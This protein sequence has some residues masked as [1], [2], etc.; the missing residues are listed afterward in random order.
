MLYFRLLLFV[1]WICAVL[2]LST[3]KFSSSRIIHVPHFIVRL[4]AQPVCSL[5]FRNGNCAS[6]AYT[7]CNM[8]QSYYRML[9]CEAWSISGFVWNHNT[10]KISRCDRLNF[11]FWLCVCVNQRFFRKLRSNWIYKLDKLTVFSL[12]CSLFHRCASFSHQNCAEYHR[13]HHQLDR[14]Q[15]LLKCL[16]PIKSTQ[17]NR[18]NVNEK[19]IPQQ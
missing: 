18:Y 3:H 2:Q 17:I 5:P 10:N 4:F 13:E 11:D 15:L 7:R 19:I 14:M 8:R 12:L 6:E 1:V 16:L 9:S